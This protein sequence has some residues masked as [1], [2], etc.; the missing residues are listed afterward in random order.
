[1][2]NVA[3]LEKIFCR[4]YKHWIKKCSFLDQI[5]ICN[6]WAMLFWAGIKIFLI[7]RTD[8]IDDD[9][10]DDGEEYDA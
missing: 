1:M 10:H 9:N 2:L 3:N 8:S 6:I 5:P 7:F 4:D